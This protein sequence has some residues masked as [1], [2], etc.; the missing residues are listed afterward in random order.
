MKKSFTII[1]F[2]LLALSIRTQGQESQPLS[3]G[4]PIG[5]VVSANPA[6]YGKVDSSGINF[7]QGNFTS[8]TRNSQIK[9]LGGDVNLQNNYISKYAMGYY[10]R[11]QAERDTFANRETGLKHPGNRNRYTNGRRMY[12][13]S[14][15]CWASDSSTGMTVNNLIWGPNYHQAK[16]YRWNQFQGLRIDYNTDFRLAFIHSEQLP[17]TTSVCRLS[18]YYH[19]NWKVT[20]SDT[21]N[22]SIILADTILRFSDF[23]TDTFFKFTLP[24]K[25][26]EYLT[27]DT[28]R[29]LPGSSYP[30]ID[31]LIIDTA[32][33]TGIEFRIDFYGKGRLYTDWIEVYDSRI[34]KEY[35]TNP[36]SVGGL[37]RTFAND[38]SSWNSLEYWFAYEEPKTLD[39][40]TPFR[41]VDSLIQSYPG[42]DKR[43]PLATIIYPAWSGQRNGD[44]YLQKFMDLAKPSK[45]M[46]DRYV[47]WT[48]ESTSKGLW[49]LANSFRDADLVQPGFWYYAQAFGSRLDNPNGD[50]CH[51]RKP[52]PEELNSSIMLALSYGSKGIMLW[53]FSSGM[54]TK[55]E[56]NCDGHYVYFDA[57]VKANGDT[58]LL[59]NYLKDELAP[60]LKGIFGN[61]LDSLTY[62][63]DFLMLR[64]NVDPP[65]ENTDATVQKNYLTLSSSGQNPAPDQIN[66]HAGF[67]HKEVDNYYFLLSNLVPD[68]DRKVN[69]EIS[70]PIQNIY[71]IRF[72]NIEPQYNFDTTFVTGSISVNYNFPSGE[73]YLFQVAPVIKYGGKLYHD[74]VI[75]KSLTLN[76]DMIIE[77][78]VTLT[79]NNNYKCKG[80][81]YLKGDAKIRTTG[82]GHITFEDG[83][84]TILL[85]S[86]H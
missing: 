1:V 41:I 48:S 65:K 77:N 10:T 36:D 45:L 7:M 4:F 43:K 28:P 23:P 70:S 6:T 29:D 9:L 30:A 63:R 31:T 51:W 47:F 64:R 56:V 62:D 50:F 18:I 42:I 15:W 38:H 37:I 21:G 84:T 85:Q 66:F 81:I 68:L 80:N 83:K 86:A 79:V 67:M 20:D 54:S 71:N 52:T 57:I 74:E 32:P 25:Y 35:I 16:K 46:L 59:Y 75:N 61:T 60:R 33:S 58:T 82:N 5:A 17:E 26:P 27:N 14:A 53:N 22:A 40:Y 73:G 3:S 69:I 49:W 34:W 24:Y 76:D 72:R 11:W 13:D 2:L 44:N 12:Y 19:Y 78:G 55:P 8:F 39:S